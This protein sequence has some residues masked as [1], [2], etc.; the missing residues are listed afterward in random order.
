[1]NAREKWERMKETFGVYDG[2]SIP[3]LENR[4]EGIKDMLK[5][6]QVLDERFVAEL[7]GMLEADE[8]RLND[9]RSKQR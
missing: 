2:K 8:K 9:L 5:S 6:R 3:Y 7:E 4:I 1:M